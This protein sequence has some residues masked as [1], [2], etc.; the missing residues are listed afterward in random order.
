MDKRCLPRYDQV[1]AVSGRLRDECL[2]L[3]VRRDRLTYVPNAV[4]P[5]EFR[6][7]SGRNEARTRL[8]VDPEH[9]AVGV[10]GRLSVEK[11]VDRAIRLLA[12]LRLKRPDAHL[13]V[14]GDGPQRNALIA[15][16]VRLEVNNR[17]TFW[18]W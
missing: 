18:G 14:I 3:G 4:D 9:F 17:V 7:R 1:I 10:V 11:G 12:R 15:L 8:G 5:N 2:S 16:A 13:H 6:R